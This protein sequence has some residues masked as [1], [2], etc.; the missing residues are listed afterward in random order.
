MRTIPPFWNVSY[1]F[2]MKNTRAA[3]PMN[4]YSSVPIALFLGLL[5]LSGCGPGSGTITG[6]L[7]LPPGVTLVATDKVSIILM[8]DDPKSQAYAA[9]FSPTDNSFVF[10]SPGKDGVP[11]AKYK[12]VVGIATL[13]PPPDPFQEFNKA[14]DADHTKLIY[15]VAPEE[16]SII[17][18]LITE[19]ITK[20]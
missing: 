1:S 15:E 3:P 20:H 8:P 2:G 16:Q 10:R 17:I 9:K 12:V 11:A 6:T 13:R 4:R 7:V 14:H 18:D 19:T 5:V